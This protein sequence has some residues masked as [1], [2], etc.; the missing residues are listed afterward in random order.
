MENFIHPVFKNCKNMTLSELENREFIRSL[1]KAELH[2][3]IE[4]T[5]EP[6]MAFQLARKHG[7]QLPY[8]DVDALRGAY[9]FS[10]L[11]SFL[12]IY[13][14]A[15]QVLQDEDDFYQL[16]HAYL[17]R[18][19][20]D[21]VVHVEIF[22]DPQSHM[23]RGVSLSVVFDGITRALE[24]A[25]REYGMTYRLI[26]C[27]LRHLSAEAAMQ[28][29]EAL[30]PY[31]N[32]IC[33][34]GLD[35]SEDGHPPSKFSQVFNRAR[36]ENFLT[37]AHAGE[38]GPPLYIWEA[39]DNLKV[40][41]IDHGVGCEVDDA[42]CERLAQERM[43]LTVCPASN[44]KLAIFK[45]M[46]EHNLKRLLQRGLC[47]TVNSDDPAYFGAYIVDNY[48]AVQQALDLSRE[49]IIRL[50]RNSIEASFLAEAEKVF[51]LGKL[52]ALNYAVS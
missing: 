48:L 1:P 40:S 10:S 27:F 4:G 18:A 29:L 17:Q 5:L 7:I 11:Q 21:G 39:L 6:E 31:R 22:F 26:P 46:E 25:E 43:P 9:S 34:V 42:L 44:I 45:S 24:G 49:D 23:E 20:T 14:Q 13:Y 33:A 16:T 50:A 3:H 15:V 19:H 35:S 12:D 30:L 8:R 28:T 32:Y 51:W 2:L 36:T 47:V 52:K 41:R 37:V 38:E